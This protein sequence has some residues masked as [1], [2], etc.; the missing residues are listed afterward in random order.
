MFV[1][2]RLKLEA[3]GP[4]S[5]SPLKKISILSIYRPNVRTEICSIRPFNEKELQTCRCALAQML[6]IVFSN[7]YVPALPKS[8]NSSKSHVKISFTKSCALYKTEGIDTGDVTIPCP[9]H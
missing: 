1:K 2:A 3:L 9:K 5:V 6:T 4:Y 7:C 8:K